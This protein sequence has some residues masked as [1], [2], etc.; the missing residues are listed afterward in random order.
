MGISRAMSALRPHL[1]VSELEKIHPIGMNP[2][3][4]S[5]VETMKILMARKKHLRLSKILKSI[6]KE[7]HFGINLAKNLIPKRTKKD[8]ATA[9]NNQVAAVKE[10]PKN[11]MIP[12]I[13]ITASNDKPPQFAWT[14]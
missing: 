9:S 1:D 11:A 13:S 4:E 12:N 5:K 7:R 3:H 10:F 6:T 14:D 2:A 8:K